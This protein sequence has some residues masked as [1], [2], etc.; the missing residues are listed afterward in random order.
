MKVKPECSHT[1]W[2]GPRRRSRPRGFNATE[3]TTGAARA[4]SSA[5]AV[6]TLEKLAD[7]RDRGVLSD[8]EFAKQKQRILDEA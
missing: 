7:L 2:S 6:D 4:G 8:E 5:E 3:M 1:R